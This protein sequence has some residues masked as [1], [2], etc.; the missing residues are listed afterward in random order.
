MIDS[1]T[2]GRLGA[3][4]FLTAVFAFLLTPFVYIA[5]GSLNDTTLS[6]PPRSIS[7]SSYFEIPPAFFHALN[8][9]LVVATAS[10][11]IAL[12][13]GISGALAVVRGRF[14]G[15]DF[16]NGLLLS[17]LLLPVLVLGASLY[18]FYFA[19][20]RTIGTA[21][22]GSLI[23]LILGHTSFCIP[24]V[25]R[26]VIPA[27]MQIPARVE[28]AA[29]DLGAS[30]WLTFRKITMPMIRTSLV[31]GGAFAFLTSFDNFPMSLF[32]AEGNNATLPVV[33]FQFIEFDL[34]PTVLAMSMLVI[35]LSL[36]AMFVIER[37]IGLATFVGLQQR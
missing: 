32:L 11:L 28:E 34:K 27:L 20:D 2:I 10:T 33:M 5:V 31:G 35:L 8:I 1:R 30:Q 6:F 36:A 18:Q 19:I 16:V 23:G 14:P 17:P 4:L 21:I 13:L 29:L 25:A 3:G 26:A 12:P 9:S 37:T 22:T 7:L 15:R 24:Y